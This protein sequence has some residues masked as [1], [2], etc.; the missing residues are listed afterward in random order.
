MSDIKSFSLCDYVDGNSIK[1]ILEA[2]KTAVDGKHEKL[3]NYHFDLIKS[4]KKMDRQDKSSRTEA[5]EIHL[6]YKYVGKHWEMCGR[7]RRPGNIYHYILRSRIIG[8]T[9]QEIQAMNYDLEVW[10]DEHI[11]PYCREHDNLCYEYGMT[12]DEPDFDKDPNLN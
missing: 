3:C 8:K 12:E 6:N 9:E 4:V 7:P 1:C 5:D 10:P 2:T 11:W